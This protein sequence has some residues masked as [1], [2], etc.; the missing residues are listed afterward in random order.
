MWLEKWREWL[1]KW[2]VRFDMP[3]V[4]WVETDVEAVT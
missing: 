4:L 1:G 3:L 2:K